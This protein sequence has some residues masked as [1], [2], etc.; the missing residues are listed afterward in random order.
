MTQSDIEP[1]RETGEIAP[2]EAAEHADLSGLLSGWIREARLLAE[3]RGLDSLVGALGG[4]AAQRRQS[5]LKVAVLGEFNR[6]KS[7]LINALIGRPLLPVGRL[8]VTRTAVRLRDASADALRLAWPD[9]RL[10]LRRLDEEDAWRGLLGVDPDS[11]ATDASGDGEPQPEV[12]VEVADSWLHG[13]GIELIDTPG[14]NGGGP[15]QLEQ[16][17]RI[18]AGADAV[19]F[20]V[21]AVSPLG[22]S[23]R[24]LIEQEALCRH[25]PHIYI[26]LTMLDLVEPAERDE[27]VRQTRARVAEFAAHARVLP[28]PGPGV[29]GAEL[30]AL[31]SLL[32]VLARDDDRALWRNRRIAATVA[33]HCDTM[34]RMAGEAV[35]VARLTEQERAQRA[36]QARADRDR[37]E[38][39]WSQLSIDLAARQLEHT[40]L[41]RELMRSERQ[42]TL[43]Y[44]HNELE[45][46]ADPRAWWERDLPLQIR[47]DLG[48]TARKTERSIL[49]RLAG[50]AAWLD[51]EVR[52][53][54]PTAGVIT[55]PSEYGLT[56]TAQVEGEVSDLTRARLAA[57]LSAQGGA[58][59]G[60]FVALTRH[61]RM[62]VLY[63]TAFSLLAG[64]VAESSIRA[65]TETQRREIDA[66]LVRI[67]DESIDAFL[68]QASEALDALYT[69]VLDQLH[70]AHTAWS[71]AFLAM[72][73]SPQNSDTAETAW[74]P[75]AGRAAQLA[76]R[77]RAALADPKG[78]ER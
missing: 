16:V 19:V 49:G 78:R 63:G 33:D 2:A 1:V 15:R 32:E 75:L 45:R 60:Y 4:L 8:P 3:Q 7:T 47:R 18:A 69:Q 59:I 31:R 42:T 29:A 55:I 62:P 43:E 50:D 21:S 65:A 74:L 12:T 36:A 5:T 51:E 46:A 11:A 28:A 14:A 44:L 77:I 71:G 67:V 34:V 26:A 54:L 17:Q 20:V 13:L 30:D 73:E 22:T 48:V 64:L 10:D 23:E 9:G 38:R 53:M 56:A 76:A 39:A 58:L 41:L 57:R 70:T 66:A 68:N 6:G 24:Q 40:H 61:A 27:A 25:V 72:L 37:A 35:A 52:R